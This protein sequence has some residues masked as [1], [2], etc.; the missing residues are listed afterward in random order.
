M[1]TFER[2]EFDAD[3][4][5]RI[6]AHVERHGE[7]DPS[8]VA[9]AAGVDPEGFNHHVT[10][11]KRDGYLENANGKL[12]VA[13]VPCETEEH[14]EAGVTYE[15][16]PAREDDL[17]GLVGAIREVSGAKTDI[18]AETVAEQ[19][20]YEDVLLRHNTVETR[21]FFVGTVGDEV[22]GWAH[23]ETPEVAKLAH[24]AELTLGVLEGYRRHGMGSHLLQRAL[25]WAA[26]NGLEKVYASLPATND[27]GVEFLRSL[28]WETEAVRED[29]YRVDGVYVDEVMLATR[30]D[31]TP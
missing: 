5:K 3:A 14:R 22:V 25:E 20:D 17:T 8:A 13:R 19:L 12:R 10:V 23:V 15:I 28:G 30:L 4:R 16:R 1:W 18:V 21:M 27:A 26:S 6:Y 31:R 24:T 7:A 29:H 2:P 11:L 9:A